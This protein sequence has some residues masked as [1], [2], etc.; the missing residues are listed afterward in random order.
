[1][2]T[3]NQLDSNAHSKAG[4]AKDTQSAHDPSVMRVTAARRPRVLL[5]E[6]SP[7][8]RERLVDLIKQGNTVELVGCAENGVQGI[9]MLIAFRPDI[10][11]L[12]LQLPGLSGFDLL[13][14]IKRERPECKVIVLTCL[15]DEATRERCMKLG[16][17]YFFDKATEFEE[18]IQV[19]KAKS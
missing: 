1:M 14:T 5:I 12:D 4:E 13:P 11:L 10:I 6:D 8:V 19:L 9:E 3:K 17:D 15:A 16:A 18:I 7:I 2:K